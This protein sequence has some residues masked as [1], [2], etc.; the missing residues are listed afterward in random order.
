MELP[1][2]FDFVTSR[3]AKKL[4]QFLDQQE[5]SDALARRTLHYG[6]QY[7]YNSRSLKKADPIPKE[8]DYLCQRLKE[9]DI[10][11]DVH[12]IIVN[13]YL[14]KQG[15]NPHIDVATFGPCVASL[16]LNAEANV[17]LSRGEKSYTYFLPP[18][19]LFWLEGSQRTKWQHS[20]PA[21]ISYLDAEGNK[22]KRAPDFRRVSLTFRTVVQ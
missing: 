17:I 16:S 1:I 7:L 9:L 6:Y 8:L 11:Q 2:I 18:R 14:Q 3:E 10:L 13:E 5:W 21:T 22:V 12:Q 4:L 15:I 19:S 20:I